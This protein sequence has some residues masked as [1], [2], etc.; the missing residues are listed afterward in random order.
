MDE[1]ASDLTV[2]ERLLIQELF[3]RYCWSLNTGDADGFV[4]C[5]ASDGWIEHFAPKRYVGHAEIRTMAENLWYGRPYRFMG[6]QHH[7]HNFLLERD[8][9]TIKARVM[10]SV[11]RL[12]QQEN[13]F[14]VF[15]LC[16]WDAVCVRENGRWRF[17]ALQIK[18]W[19]RHE[20]PWVGD[21]KARLVLPGDEN[22]KPG[23]F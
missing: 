17:S 2:E 3:A 11:T 22:K 8:G 12:L 7:P 5:F 16:N 9:E 1:A 14:E 21:P 15:L 13:R 19:F 18:H 20:A 23:E 4:A 6:R 10:A